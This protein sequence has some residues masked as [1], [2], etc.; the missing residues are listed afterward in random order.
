[1]SCDQ[2]HLEIGI[3]MV[4]GDGVKALGTYL[5]IY[6]IPVNTVLASIIVAL[7]QSPLPKKSCQNP[8]FMQFLCENLRTKARIFEL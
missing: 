7:D 8:I 4:H 1:M 5:G 2:L 6:F 3:D